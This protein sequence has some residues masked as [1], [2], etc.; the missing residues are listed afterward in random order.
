MTR[1]H[2]AAVTNNEN[3]PS[4]LAAPEFTEQKWRIRS[5]AVCP[6][7]GRGGGGGPLGR[8]EE[9]AEEISFLSIVVT[10][11]TMRPRD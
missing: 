6:R 9:M 3:D 1:A 7:G 4:F 5:F 10:I 11:I 8:G 2:R